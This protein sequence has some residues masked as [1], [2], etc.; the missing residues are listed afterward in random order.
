LL[1]LDDTII[2]DSGG[3][4]SSWREACSLCSHPGFVA[5]VNSVREWYWSDS[6][7]HRV[8]RLDLAVARRQIV[9]MALQQLGID[10]NALADAMASKYGALRDERITLIP[11]AVE[12][13]ERFRAQ[14]CRTAL[15]TNG[16]GTAQRAKIARFNL[17]PL[18]DAVLVEG[19]L[20]YGKPDQRI[21]EAGLRMLHAAAADA[22]MV[23]D[24][25]A[26][27]VAPAKALGI[28][29]V[30]VDAENRGLPASAP[31]EPD[32]IVRSLAHLTRP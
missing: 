30:W 4:D 31:C 1:D 26:W 11:G 7:R 21:F 3:V 22:W 15:L 9:A 10:D 32:R 20:G 25:L 28:C 8:G 16:A 27:D 12:T 23:G 6:A 5:E 24:N 18:F 17:E 19:E 13:I 29:A 2:D 14:G